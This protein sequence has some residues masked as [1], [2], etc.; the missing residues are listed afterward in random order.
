MSIRIEKS[1]RTLK[2]GQNDSSLLKKQFLATFSMPPQ[3]LMGAFIRD[4]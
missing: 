2:R 4:L 3:N 1:C